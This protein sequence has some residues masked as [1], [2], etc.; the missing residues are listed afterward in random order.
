VSGGARAAARTG[1]FRVLGGVP[2]IAGDREG[3]V[4]ELKTKENDASVEAF[5]AR[6]VD[7]ARRDDC[8]AVVEMMR[9]VTGLEPRMWGPSIVGFGSY[10]YT[11]A[12]GHEGDCCLVGFSPRKKDLT[13]YILPGFDRYADLM[14]RLGKYKT[15]KSCLYLRRLADVDTSVLRELVTAGFAYMRQTKTQ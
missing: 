2:E 8:L 15:G 14:G 11:Y 5:L 3:P 10:H 12:S 4:A 6:V 7:E 1:K 13:L 9:E